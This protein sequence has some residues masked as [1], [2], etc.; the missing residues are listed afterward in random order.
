MGDVRQPDPVPPHRGFLT[1]AKALTPGGAG[2][3]LV[4]E[5]FS[6]PTAPHQSVVWGF[7]IPAGFD[8]GRVAELQRTISACATTYGQKRI[9]WAYVPEFVFLPVEESADV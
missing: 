7:T 4:G 3:E 2:A 6:L 1:T 9:T 5:W 8:Q